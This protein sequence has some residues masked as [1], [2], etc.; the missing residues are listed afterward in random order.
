VAHFFVEDENQVQ[1]FVKISV[2]TDG[3]NFEIDNVV[4]DID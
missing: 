2:N 4:P 3:V 1:A